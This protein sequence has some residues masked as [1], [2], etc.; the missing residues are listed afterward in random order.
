MDG[1]NLPGSLTFVLQAALMI[2]MAMGYF[3]ATSGL[4]ASYLSIVLTLRYLTS[5]TSS[6]PKVPQMASSAVVPSIGI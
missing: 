1:E 4:F 5:T 3:L 6:L 2:L